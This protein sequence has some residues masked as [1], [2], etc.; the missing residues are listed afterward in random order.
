MARTP[1]VPKARHATARSRI[2]DALQ[3]GVPF[4]L[5]ELSGEVGLS[6]RDLPSHLEHLQRSLKQ[7]GRKLAIEP[8][9]CLDCGFVFRERTR[10]TK[11]GKCP[12]C[13]GT[14]IEAPRVVLAQC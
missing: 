8:A 6:E 3:V 9:S 13:R 11:P 2:L 10:F 7:R 14:H 4:T 12:A 1:T 5:K